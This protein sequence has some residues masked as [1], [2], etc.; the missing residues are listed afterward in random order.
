MWYKPRELTNYQGAGYE[1]AS[2]SLGKDIDAETAL[3][4]WKTSPSHHDVMINR[5][6]WKN[7][8]WNAIGVGIY[9]GFAVVWFGEEE[10]ADGKPEY[11]TELTE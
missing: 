6:T 10:D 7:I 8:E 9:K 1:I 5:R 3:D 2:W 4:T 11:C